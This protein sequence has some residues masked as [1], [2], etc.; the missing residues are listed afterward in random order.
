M[1]DDCPR[2]IV[3]EVGLRFATYF[4]NV[5][6]K[7]AQKLRPGRLL[8]QR[9][10]ASGSPPKRLAKAS[11]SSGLEKQNTTKWLS[12]RRREYVSGVADRTPA[13]QKYHLAVLH[14]PHVFGRVRHVMRP[15]IIVGDFA[16]A[17][18]HR[19]ATAYR[20]H[21]SVLNS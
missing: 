1:A 3:F 5:P 17:A 20:R 12:S 19:R 4:Q 13:A 11:A 7:A 15:L 21:T 6:S 8:R 14:A 18:V 16:L 2:C 10:L 9:Q